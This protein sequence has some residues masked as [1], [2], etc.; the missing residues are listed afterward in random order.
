MRR[1]V[2]ATAVLVVALS[3]TAWASPA[4]QVE[5]TAARLGPAA[6]P[7]QAQ[8]Q[9]AL[10]APSVGA[11]IKAGEGAT[12]LALAA[13]GNVAVA[14]GLIPYIRGREE[15]S[16]PSGKSPP[17]FA[18][19]QRHVKAHAAGCY[20]SPSNQWTWT[21]AGANVGWVYVRENGWCGSGGRI[22]WYGG[23]TFAHWT[24]FPW[25]LTGEGTDYSW[26]VYPSWIHMA[27]WGTLGLSYPWG[28][29]GYYGGKAPVRIAWN[30]YWDRY[31][32]YGF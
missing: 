2:V 28:C 9:V 20:G 7:Q 31:N 32:D 12:V 13:K 25:C 19:R 26:D 4:S 22:T 17:A 27:H 24:Q 29:A 23:P 6:N 14:A 3:T 30:G 8:A 11:A 21:V 15:A 18:A 16:P 10:M 5:E 1:I